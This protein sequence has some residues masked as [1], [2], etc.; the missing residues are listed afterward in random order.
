MSIESKLLQ[1]AERSKQAERLAGTEEATKTSVILPFIQ[2]LGFDVFDLNEVIPEFTAD[3]GTKKGEK[4]DFAIKIKGEVAVL[5]EAKPIGMSLG[6]TQVSQLYR[7]FSVTNARVAIL[8]NEREFLFYSDTET[9]NVMDKKPFFKVDIQHMLEKDLVE[10]SKFQKDRFDISTIIEAASNQRYIKA[11][12]DFLI[13][14]LTSPSDE[15]V[16]YVAKTFYDGV[17]TKSV[18]DTMRP[19]VASAMDEVLKTQLSAKLGV[20]FS[21]IQKNEEDS[22]TL[23]LGEDTDNGIETTEE[24]IQ[25]FMIIRAIGMREIDM[26]RITMRDSK[27]YCA[28]FADDN[29]RKP[30]CRFYFNSKTD[31]QIGIF[32]PDKNENRHRLQKLED[33]YQY[34]DEIRQAVAAYKST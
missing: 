7:Y 32:D 30:I 17:I 29:N 12:A 4:V 9:P 1:I 27:S 24:E 14:E 2:S 5:I 34:S 28:V 21:P 22:D 19:A 23:A 15:F 26:G 11:A 6:Q 10:L 20:A 3:V 31:K 25:A 18:L 16:R 8:T 13:K 33:I